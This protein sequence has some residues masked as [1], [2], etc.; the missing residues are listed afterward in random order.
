MIF[1][2][3]WVSFRFHVHFQGCR[4]L[5][6]EGMESFCNVVFLNHLLFVA[7]F[8]VPFICPAAKCFEVMKFI[9]IK[10]VP[11]QSLT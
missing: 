6:G 8:F 4:D 5:S 11:S 9:N 1:Q 3:H 7:D 2:I 10:T